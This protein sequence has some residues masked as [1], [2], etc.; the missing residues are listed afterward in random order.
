MEITIPAASAVASITGYYAIKEGGT[1][2]LKCTVS[3]S[4]PGPW[5]I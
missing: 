5:T 1:D 3:G 4:G 2:I